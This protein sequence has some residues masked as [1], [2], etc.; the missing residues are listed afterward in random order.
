MKMKHTALAVMTVLIA[1]CGRTEASQS[2]EPHAAATA[3]ADAPARVQ[4]EDAIVIDATLGSHRYVA[5]GA[6]ECSHAPAASIYGMP[7]EMWLVQYGGGGD[8]QSLSL[9]LWRP[10]SGEGDQLSL[11]VT[12]DDHTARIATVAGGRMEGSA[13]VA[14]ET[15]GAGSRLRVEGRDADGDRVSVTVRCPRFDPLEAVGG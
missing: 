10:A 14:M 7:A 15:D 6:G 1:A 8:V 12:A 3:Q 13:R 4:D 2:D 5:S 9:T 11:S